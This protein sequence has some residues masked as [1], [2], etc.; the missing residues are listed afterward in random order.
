MNFL[1][2]TWYTK[3]DIPCKICTCLF[4]NTSELKNHVDKE[5]SDPDTLQFMDELDLEWVNLWRTIK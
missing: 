1:V 3:K 2:R 4:S 5:H